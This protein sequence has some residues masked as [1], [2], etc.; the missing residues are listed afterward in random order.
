MGKL[1]QRVRKIEKA[2]TLPMTI[3]ELIAMVP[4]LEN[5]ADEPGPENPIL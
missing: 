1:K 5:N 4:P 3:A 2:K